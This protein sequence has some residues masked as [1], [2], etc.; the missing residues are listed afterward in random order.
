M[1]NREDIFVMGLDSLH[2][3][4]YRMGNASSPKFTETHSLIDCPVVNT[5]GIRT[6]IAN[7]NGFS[8]FNHITSAMKTQANSI[9]VSRRVVNFLWASCLPKTKLAKGTTC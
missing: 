7:G 4:L 8:A 3:D 6:V 2:E 5:A 9:G 1:L